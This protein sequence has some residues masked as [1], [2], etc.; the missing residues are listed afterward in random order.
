MRSPGASLLRREI[1]WQF[2]DPIATSMTSVKAVEVVECRRRLIRAGLGI[3]EACHFYIETNVAK[4]LIVCRARGGRAYP[5][6]RSHRAL[7]RCLGT[8]RVLRVTVLERQ[9]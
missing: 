7:V 4:V 6:S 1:E 2:L 5:C 8:G 3:V 9:G